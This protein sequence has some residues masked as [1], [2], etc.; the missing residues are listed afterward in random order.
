MEKLRDVSSQNACDVKLQNVASTHATPQ[1]DEPTHQSRSLVSH[2][3]LVLQ[4]LWLWL[5][6]PVVLCWCRLTQIF[7]RP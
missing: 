1:P 2:Q 4:A 5:L 6:T 3:H 7:K